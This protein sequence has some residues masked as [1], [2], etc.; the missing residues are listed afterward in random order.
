MPLRGSQRRL[1]LTFLFIVKRKKP[2]HREVMWLAWRHTARIVSKNS[3]SSAPLT[4]AAA[5]LL[6]VVD[7]DSAPS[8]APHLPPTTSF[9]GMGQ[10]ALGPAPLH[11]P[12]KTTLFSGP[13]LYSP[14]SQSLGVFYFFFSKELFQRLIFLVFVT[15]PLHGFL[16]PAYYS[17]PSVSAGDWF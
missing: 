3:W 1:F 11:P 14:V 8:P 4:S 9:L 5:S 6:S 10:P 13:E 7:R 17:W 2:C 15:A 16:S 12:S